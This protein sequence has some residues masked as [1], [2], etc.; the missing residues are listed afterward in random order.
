MS[1]LTR[2]SCSSCVAAAAQVTSSR[3]FTRAAAPQTGL[4]CSGIAS[5]SSSFGGRPVGGALHAG[6]Q[7]PTARPAR[8][9]SLVVRA[10][11]DYYATLGVDRGA[12]KKTIKSAYRQLARKYHPDV[13]KVLLPPLSIPLTR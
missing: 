2:T 12:D 6:V 13:N 10:D 5:R 1:S 11:A 4:H 9:A 3:R 7:Q 8:G